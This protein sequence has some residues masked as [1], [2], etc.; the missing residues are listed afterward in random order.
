MDDIASPA[1][2][3]MLP[4]QGTP[5][6]IGEGRQH[7]GADQDL[8]CTQ[9]EHRLPHHPEPPRAQFK[10]DQ[11]QQHDHAQRCDA[12]NLVNIAD[13][14]KAGWPDRSAGQQIAEHAAEAEAPG[15][16]HRDGRGGEKCDERC[17]HQ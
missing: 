7:H 1:P 8:A 12:G 15:Q 13:K 4:G 9:A 11:E 3:T 5:A 17:Q 2:R 16:R 10:P 6:A 14:A